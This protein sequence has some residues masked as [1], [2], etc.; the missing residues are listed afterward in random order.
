MCPH[1]RA[2][3]G[4]VIEV[5]HGNKN[6]PLISSIKIPA[7]IAGS[8]AQWTE[9]VADLKETKGAQDLFFVFTD[10]SGKKNL[11][12]IDWIYFGNATL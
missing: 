6:G 12:D 1:D 7:R 5:H 8:Q 11:F 3:S 9:M 4:G 10:E 2:Q